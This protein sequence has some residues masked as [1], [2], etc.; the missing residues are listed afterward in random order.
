MRI[1]ADL[2]PTRGDRIALDSPYTAKDLIRTI[3]GA[4][5]SKDDNK[6]SVPLAW[7]ACLALRAVFGESLEVGDDLSKWAWA[8]KR[9]VIDPAMALRERLDAPGDERL[10]DFQRAG[11]EFLAL[12]KRALLADEMGSGKTVQTIFALRKLYDAGDL[13][14]EV[15]I[16]C[17]NTMKRT[18]ERELRTWWGDEAVTIAVVSG[19]AEQRRKKIRSGAKFVIINWEA[20]RTHSRLTAFGS[21]ALK[22]CVECG[23]SGTVKQAQCEVHERELNEMEYS[24][25][26]ADEVHKAKDPNSMQT[27]ALWAASG[28]T[29]IRFG[30]TGTPIANDPTELWPILHWMDSQEWPA[31]TA[32]VNRLIDFVYNIWGGM[33]VNG[34]KPTMEAEFR[35]TVDP[36]M[37]RMPKELVL[38]FLPPIVSERR[39]VDM[40][41][42]QKKAYEQMRDLMIARLDAGVL[43][44]A[45]P[46]VQVGR[47]MQLA[48]SHGDIKI[49]PDTGEERLILT[50]PSAKL[51]AFIADL[52]DFE[53]ASSIVFAESRQLIDLASA[54][55]HKKGIRHGLITGAVGTDARDRTIEDFQKGLFPFIL[56]TIKAG[57]VGITLTK[58]SIE[59]FIQRNW[60]WIERDQ[61]VAR[62]HRIGSEEHES[63][64]VVDYVTTGTVEEVQ[65]KTLASKK[66]MLEEIVRDEEMM[67]KFLRGEPIE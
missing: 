54:R 26:V 13:P 40:A 9:D 12:V 1:E 51:D 18:W 67:R 2:H 23:G 62:A 41:P 31:K 6:W 61:S 39:D 25:I 22:K 20:L 7:T 17:P 57:G 30:L 4:R 42:A 34:I 49:D 3:P 50:D 60:S 10:Y 19:T 52:P 59:I 43:M 66:G 16:V 37:R 44:A 11:V 5:W 27:R 33:D 32:W 53:G 64:T 24:A 58:A 29:E 63:I 35:A 56:C 65:L 28:N 48:S 47:L 55:L 15:L 38:P 21:H 36:H 46:M 45:N 14:G 8:L